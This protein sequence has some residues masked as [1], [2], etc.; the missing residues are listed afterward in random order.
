ME[1]LLQ[2]RAL[3]RSHLRED[4]ELQQL[5]RSNFVDAETM[6]RGPDSSS[7]AAWKGFY[8]LKLHAF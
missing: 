6:C 2:N 8:H 7:G 4:L 1:E 5:G 3:L